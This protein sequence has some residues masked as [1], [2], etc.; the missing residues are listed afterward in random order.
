MTTIEERN[1]AS[2]APSIDS[3]ATFDAK[4]ITTMHTP[5]RSETCVA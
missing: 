3:I 2:V 5:D 4:R 1:L